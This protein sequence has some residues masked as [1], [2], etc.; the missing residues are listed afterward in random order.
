[1]PRLESGVAALGQRV[2]I[3]GGFITNTLDVTPAVDVF[4]PNVGA[5]GTW[6]ASAFP[7][8]PVLRHHIQLVSI[9]TTLYFLGGLDAMLSGTSFPARGDSWTLDTLTTGAT[10]TQIKSMPLGKERGSAGIVV[11]PPRIYLIGGAATTTALADIIYY[12]LDQNVWCPDPSGM[13]TAACPQ[14]FP[15]LP[16]A[17]SHLAATRRS[18]GTFVVAGGL[19]GLTPDTSVDT[20]YTLA[21]NAAA[22]V[23]PPMTMSIPTHG[24]AL[25]SARGGC[26]YGVIAG[27]LVCAGGEGGQ[28]AFHLVQ[29]YNA[30]TNVWTQNC[31]MPDDRA[32]TQGAAIGERLFV[33]GG[34]HTL[35]PV[36]EPLDSMV[37]Y[38]P[39]D[40]A[41]CM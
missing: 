21:P 25:S 18:D 13:T 30:L 2:V 19:A 5:T 28:A 40:T 29:S 36:Y 20:V 38:A 6:Q 34:S 14:L 9:G 35:P 11:A 15:P 4:D 26:A 33:P 12:D 31:D 16:V 10:W 32:G 37:V 17:L 24:A 23:G 7:D 22:W 8:L 3:A 1:M 27:Q 41:T 39:L